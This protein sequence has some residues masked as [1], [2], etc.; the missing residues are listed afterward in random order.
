MTQ[1]SEALNCSR[2]SHKM[3]FFHCVGQVKTPRIPH[4]VNALD[5]EKVHIKGAKSVSLNRAVHRGRQKIGCTE[6]I[7]D[8]TISRH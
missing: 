3:D 7:K 8:D 4:V 5:R 2:G 1:G 6:L